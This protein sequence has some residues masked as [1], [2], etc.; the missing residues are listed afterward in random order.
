MASGKFLAATAILALAGAG[1]AGYALKSGGPDIIEY[2][3]SVAQSTPKGAVPDT[4]PP[5]PLETAAVVSEPATEP[6]AALRLEKAPSDAPLPSQIRNVAP[7]GIAAPQVNGPLKR[8]AAPERPKEEDSEPVPDGPLVLR[9]PQVVDAGTLKTDNYTVRL[10]HIEALPG[11]ETC[12]SRLGG[13]WPCGAR[14]RTSLRGLVRMFS[15]ECEKVEDLG[16]REFT[17]VCSRKNISLNAWLVEYGWAQPRED[18]PQ[19]FAALAAKARQEKRGMWQSEWL[20]ELPPAADLA[21]PKFGI[22]EAQGPVEDTFAI[23]SAD[24][25]ALPPS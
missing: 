21:V 15:V 4:T 17:A 22:D 5:A 8:I 23:E 1:A 12:V 7:T 24:L 9:R 13:T 16:V 3:G 19:E 18:A 11:D 6:P 25:P 14:A 2:E 20:S 10:A